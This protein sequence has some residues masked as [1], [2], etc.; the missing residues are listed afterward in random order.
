VVAVGFEGAVA[1]A[2]GAGT[3]RRLVVSA[4]GA[5]RPGSEQKFALI[6][7]VIAKSRL[8]IEER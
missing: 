7:G 8:I 5:T 6:T 4:K 2:A 3:S 1:P